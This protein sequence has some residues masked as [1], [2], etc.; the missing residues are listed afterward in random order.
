M[1]PRAFQADEKWGAI[2]TAS[3]R[4]WTAPSGSRPASRRCASVYF[5]EAFPGIA[6]WRTE[7]TPPLGLEAASD[8]EY[9]MVVWTTPDLSATAAL[10]TTVRRISP[11]PFRTTAMV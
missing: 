2:A 4:L 3:S 9:G 10:T 5:A 6:S 11:S 8:G 7:T 1:T